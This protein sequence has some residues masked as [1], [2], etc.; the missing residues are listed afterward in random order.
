MIFNLPR[1][2]G[3]DKYYIRRE[4]IGIDELPKI[5]VKKEEGKTE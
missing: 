5:D 1:I 4:Y 3:G 2:E